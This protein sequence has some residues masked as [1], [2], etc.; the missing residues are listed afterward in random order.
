MGQNKGDV[1]EKAWGEV[2][3]SKLPWGCHVP[4]SS[5]DKPK[6]TWRLPHHE[7]A[8][9][10]GDDGM[11][12]E[13]G[14]LNRAGVHA[15][16]GRFNQ[17]QFESSAD[18]R[19]A[20]SHLV[21]AYKYMDEEAPAVLVDAAKGEEGDVSSVRAAVGAGGPVTDA[22][23]ALINKFA[24][25]PLGADNVYVF[26]VIISTDKLDSYGT[27]MDETTL[28]N[29]A[30]DARA[31]LPFMNSH[32]TGGFFSGAELPH[33]KIFDGEF[34]ADAEG[35]RVREWAYLQR[36]IALNGQGN[37][38]LIAAMSGGTVGSVSVGF[39]TRAPLAPN[40][41]YKCDICGANLLSSACAHFPLLWY[42]EKN[43]VVPPN[44]Q[45]AKMATAAI[46]EAHQI[47]G[48]MVWM[49]AT[50]GA[51][52]EKA[53]SMAGSLGAEA[54][55]TLED[56]YGVRLMGDNPAAYSRKSCDDYHKEFIG[57]LAESVRGIDSILATKIEMTGV[58]DPL[59][60]RLVQVTE[61]MRDSSEADSRAKAVIVESEQ[62]HKRVTELE[63]ALCDCGKRREAL[64]DSTEFLRAELAELGELA[65]E[66]RAYRADLIER[67]VIA[68]VRAQGNSF[69]ADGYRE[70]LGKSDLDY[71]KS[72]IAAHEA[73]LEERYQPGRPTRQNKKRARVDNAHLYQ[74]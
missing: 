71:I 10:V 20:A 4:V 40:A 43:N 59:I 62:W 57:A 32:R 47:E 1:S 74:G 33:G 41:W 19:N 7:G 50:P 66:G 27:H 54:V 5:A 48:S 56:A 23:L 70:A 37:D 11:Y 51:I 38:D 65:E 17:T 34:V 60:D 14:A 3:K 68:R 53:R 64:E 8:G 31:G 55:K 22:Q 36:G 16:A 52:V 35:K 42:D 25:S 63:T 24:A 67:A 21:S 18:K 44:T 58:P 29:F 2:D 9:S 12:P 73:T 26:P 28:R 13:V 46:I 39:A 6:S 49:G 15:A 69:D 30:Q 61:W 45:G 72:E